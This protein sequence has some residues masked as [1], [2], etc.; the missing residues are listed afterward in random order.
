MQY[1]QES[2]QSNDRRPEKQISANSSNTRSQ[3][4]SKKMMENLCNNN[5]INCGVKTIITR[6]RCK[7]SY[8]RVMMARWI[9]ND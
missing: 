9:Q 6:K 8:K 2:Y 3:K 4:S 5:M 1:K 7:G